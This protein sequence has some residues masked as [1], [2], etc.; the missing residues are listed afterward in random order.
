MQ[1]RVKM[2]DT[3]AEA[4]FS[5]TTI[6]G[7]G[8]TG[9][10]VAEG[11]CR[12]LPVWEDLLLIDHDRV[13]PHNLRRQNFYEGD[14]GKFKAQILAERLARQYARKIGYCTRPYT[15]HLMKG[16][17]LGGHFQT[18]AAQGLVIGCVDNAAARLEIRESLRWQSWW[19]DA[20][21]GRSSGQVLL[22]N[23]LDA[24]T[25]EKAFNLKDQTVYALPAPSLQ[26]PGLLI[27]APVRTRDCAQAIEDDQSP[28][29]NQAMATLVLE[30]VN[31]LM[32]H[33]LYWMGA[34]LDLDAGT[35]QTVPA[36]PETVGR[37]FGLKANT[38]S[39]KGQ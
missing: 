33:S 1:F 3:P 28:V 35:L 15:R 4:F 22:G 8:G 30:F 24:E 18:Y 34:Y 11:L 12:I 26:A 38:L 5:S 36:N 32:S 14:V 16:S 23:A 9:G 39:E 19:L 13:E 10:F 17:E 29:I 20:G 2:R 25:M 21:N 27:P 7:C 6:V 37:I 31:K